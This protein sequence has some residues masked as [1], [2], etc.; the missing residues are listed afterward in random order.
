[1]APNGP[2][3][4]TAPTSIS[5]SKVSAPGA[6]QPSAIDGGRW[7]RTR[8]TPAGCCL[9]SR[10]RTAEARLRSGLGTGGRPVHQRV[11]DSGD[12]LFDGDAGQYPKRVGGRIRPAIERGAA[13]RS[14]PG[15][16][17]RSSPKV[18]SIHDAT[19]SALNVASSVGAGP[20][21]RVERAPRK[22]GS[23]SCVEAVSPIT[24]SGV[25][26]APNSNVAP[27]PV[28]STE[29]PRSPLPARAGRSRRAIRGHSWRA[30]AEAPR[31][32]AEDQELLVFQTSCSR[33]GC[34][35]RPADC[36]VRS[37]CAGAF[38]GHVSVV[39]SRAPERSGV[40]SAANADT[41]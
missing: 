20:P 40:A 12:A 31:T 29:G 15:P 33:Y 26:S 6:E 2:R 24:F 1:M 14:R 38:R 4:R 11:S 36:V 16:R 23:S 30:A 28:G 22:A 32:D 27:R 9:P 10:Q 35:P 39:S 25:T 8:D 13:R 19:G 18:V 7:W 34:A 21:I 37:R 3:H 17:L 5:I 41:S